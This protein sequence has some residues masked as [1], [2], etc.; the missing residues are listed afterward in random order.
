MEWS[1]EE[2][3]G[4]L[5]SW[6]YKMMACIQR[7]PKTFVQPLI[8]VYEQLKIYKITEQKTNNLFNSKFLNFLSCL[9]TMLE[10][11]LELHLG[12]RQIKEKMSGIFHLNS[13]CQ[14]IEKRRKKIP[15]LGQN[16]PRTI[17]QRGIKS[18]FE[19]FKGVSVLCSLNVWV[20]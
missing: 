3:Q 13:H 17:F 10:S 20:L 19:E 9:K 1:D 11:M 2:L 14:V 4:I 15:K 7:E 12:T 16:K 18:I 6:Q 8:Q 5:T